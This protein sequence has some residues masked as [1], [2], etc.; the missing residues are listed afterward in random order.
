MGLIA[1]LLSG[2][3]SAVVIEMLAAMADDD[4]VCDAGVISEIDTDELGIRLSDTVFDVRFDVDFLSVV[5]VN[6][7]AH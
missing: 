1:V 7:L 2:L 3:A 6:I 5:G 4:F